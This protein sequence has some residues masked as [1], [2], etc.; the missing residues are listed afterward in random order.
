MNLIVNYG[1]S[2]IKLGLVILFIILGMGELSDGVYDV[3]DYAVP[4]LICLLVNDLYFN[5]KNGNLKTDTVKTSKHSQKSLKDRI[6]KFV[7]DIFYSG[8]T[9]K[10]TKSEKGMKIIMN[11]VFLILCLSPIIMENLNISYVV[12]ND[13]FKLGVVIWSGVFLAVSL[14]DFRQ[15]LKV[16][17]LVF[18]N[19]AFLIL[20]GSLLLL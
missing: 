9:E 6:T 2:S 16:S 10:M 11:N 3:G 18:S 7:K 15:S 4:L 12:K 8:S 13:V 1:I 17:R 5:Y 14:N 20:L 19:M